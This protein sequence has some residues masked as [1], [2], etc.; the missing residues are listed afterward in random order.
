[1]KI[2]KLSKPVWVLVGVVVL[3]VALS[4]FLLLAHYTTTNPRFCLTCHGTGETADVGEESNIHPDYSDV[5][6][7][8]CHA[9]DGGHFVTDGY[10]TGFE[11]EPDRVS[12]N[13]VRCHED[14]KQ[15]TDTEGFKYNEKNIRIPHAMHFGF[16][17]V[18][19]DCHRN[20]AHDLN[21]NQTNRPTMAYCFQCHPATD[22]CDKCHPDGPPAEKTTIPPPAK[23]PQ[24][25]SADASRATFELQCAKCHALYP[26]TL[27]S[28]AEWAPVVDRMV[29]Y[30]GADISPEDK[31]LIMAYIDAAAKP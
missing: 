24:V 4:P 19:T 14:M 2:P 22:K 5:G 16:G 7:L 12:E 21:V 9:E 31:A 25:P 11:S 17:A 20:L 8:D 1:M 28:K 29:G 26:V 3:L 23:R 15:K 13:C 6:C 30:T 18:C 10:K 27:Y